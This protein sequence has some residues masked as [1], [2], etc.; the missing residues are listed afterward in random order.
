MPMNVHNGYGII[1]RLYYFY[2]T[3]QY[4]VWTRKGRGRLSQRKYLDTDDGFRPLYEAFFVV[5]NYG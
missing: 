2:T 5:V 1:G 4:V 3:V